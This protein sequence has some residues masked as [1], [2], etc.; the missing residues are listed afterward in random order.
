MD[1]HSEVTNGNTHS[2]FVL[3]FAPRR[4]RLRSL[5]LIHMSYDCPLDKVEIEQML[6]RN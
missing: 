3:V 4:P 6:L 2:G 1:I 5:A